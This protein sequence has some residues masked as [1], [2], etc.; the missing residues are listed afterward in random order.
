MKC[1]KCGG[2]GRVPHEIFDCSALG[3]F[4]DNPDHMVH[5]VYDKK[6]W[7]CFGSGKASW[8]ERLWAKLTKQRRRCH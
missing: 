3:V 4:C 2:L 6:C 5:Y 1:R 7:L 8:P